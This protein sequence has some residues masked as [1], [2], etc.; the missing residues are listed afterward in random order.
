MKTLKFVP[1]LID[2]IL[3]GEKTSTWRLYDDK[4]LKAGDELELVNKETLKTAAL[5][6]IEDVAVRKL[7]ALT[8][9]DWQGHEKFTS[10][11]DMYRSYRSYYPDREVG[12]ETEVK[13]IKFRLRDRSK[14]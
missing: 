11:D 4:D 7:G 8:P 9:A 13:I 12:P 10:S 2:Q 3:S 6:V 1:H 5:A 14:S